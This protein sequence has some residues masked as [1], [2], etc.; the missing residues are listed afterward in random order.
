M[1]HK[2]D[3]SGQLKGLHSGASCCI[4]IA[5]ADACLYYTTTFP[6][7]MRSHDCA[8]CPIVLWN[9]PGS[10]LQSNNSSFSAPASSQSLP[11]S[12]DWRER[13]AV[14]PVKNQADISGILINRVPAI[15]RSH[16]SVYNRNFPCMEAIYSYAIKNQRGASKRPLVGYLVGGILRSKALVGGFRCDVLV[17]YG[18]R[19]LA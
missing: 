3:S 1:R 6:F 16:W 7:H 5:Y 12:V 11:A 14:T 13:G 4:F 2:H 10:C 8:V 15:L 9:S 19:L 17:L 18:T